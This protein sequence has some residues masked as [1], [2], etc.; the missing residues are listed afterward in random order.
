[1]ERSAFGSLKDNDD[2]GWTGLFMAPSSG[3]DRSDV[4]PAPLLPALQRAFGELH[5]L[6]AFQQRKFVGRILA[7]VPDEHFP[8]LL[9]TVV[10][11]DIL[12]QLLPVAVEIVQTLLVGIPHRPR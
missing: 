7:N 1:M 11:D 3:L 9:E 8:L 4:D 10:V 12:R 6:G 2:I 5:A